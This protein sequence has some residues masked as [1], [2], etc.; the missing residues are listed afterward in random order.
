MVEVLHA[1][2]VSEEL[3]SLDDEHQSWTMTVELPGPAADAT[4]IM[5]VREFIDGRRVYTV[6]VLTPKSNDSA[7]D[8]E[9]FLNSF[10]IIPEK[11]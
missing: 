11:K 4:Q 7:A 8:A 2:I 9:A 10:R 3:V 5:R 1:K 6:T